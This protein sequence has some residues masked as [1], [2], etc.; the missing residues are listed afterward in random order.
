M[1]LI[2]GFILLIAFVG[3]MGGSNRS[4]VPNRRGGVI[5]K[6]Y[7]EGQPTKR[8]KVPPAPQKQKK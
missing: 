7:P 8:P 4:A 2:I 3:L 1:E 6:D 5:I